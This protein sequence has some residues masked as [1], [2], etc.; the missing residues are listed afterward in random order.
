MALNTVTPK[1]SKNA[2]TQSALA[3]EYHAGDR[4]QA[5]LIAAENGERAETCG[6]CG[7]E[8]FYRHTVGMVQC[9]GCRAI[10]M[11]MITNAGESVDEWV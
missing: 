3:N 6:K 11:V 4:V 8:A 1:S 9:P 7:A 10:H 5:E 2:W